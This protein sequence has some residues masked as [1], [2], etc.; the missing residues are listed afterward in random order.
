MQ[1]HS[2]RSTGMI[3]FIVRLL[4]LSAAFHFVLP[5]IKGITVHGTFVNSIGLAFFFSVLAW[6]V[7]AFAGLVTALLT[8]GTL[9]L[10]LL[11]LIPI[12]LVGF[13]LF[14]AVALK[15]VADFM[16]GYL[17]VDGWWPAIWGGLLMFFVGVVTDASQVRRRRDDSD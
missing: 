13:W 5:M 8:V 4:A 15:L 17:V 6:L 7:S 2:L 10:A 11:V 1:N 16:P 12:W 3:K 9:G 14:P